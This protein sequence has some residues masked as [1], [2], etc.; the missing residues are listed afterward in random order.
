[1]WTVLRTFESEP[2]A[3]V[4]EAFLQAN[5]IHVQL[6]GTHS[7]YSIV[8]PGSRRTLGLRLMVREEQLA[9]AK[10]LL[11]E[12]EARAHLTVVT[13]GSPPKIDKRYDKIIVALLLVVIAILTYLQ[14]MY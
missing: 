12:Q 9:A 6:L 3:R 4:V 14:L 7:T 8:A 10:Q 11:Q 13:E 1:M 5:E 2:E